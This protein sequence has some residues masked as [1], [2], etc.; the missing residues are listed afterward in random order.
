MW[1]AV[2]K[3]ILYI[4]FVVLISFVALGQI[5]FAYARGYNTSDT[6][7]QTG[8]VVSLSPNTNGA[9]NSVER[10]TQATSS[11]VVGIVTTLDRTVLATSPGK[12]TVLVENDAQVDAYVS[13]INGSIQAGDQLTVSQLKGILAKVTDAAS[14]NVIAVAADDPKDAIE[15]TYEDNGQT[16]KTLIHKISVSLQHKTTTAIDVSDSALTKFGR[17][18]TGKDIGE[19]RLILAMFIFLIV[20]IAEGGILYG[21]L[22]G[23]IMAIGRNPLAKKT[24]R[25]E[26]LRVI[27]IATLILAV[28]LTAMYFMIWV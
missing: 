9:N 23:A 15:Y 19:F 18:V 11:S 27:L 17:Q 14:T 7:L 24:I 8:M 10:A 3:R 13:D 25:Q 26:L 1:R 12:A 16:K 20:L 21:G 6:G 22:S 28:G 5:V 2:N 4:I